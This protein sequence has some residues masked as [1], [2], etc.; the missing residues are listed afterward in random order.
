[1]GKKEKKTIYILK[2]SD[3][4]KKQIEQARKCIMFAVLPIYVVTTMKIATRWL[5]EDSMKFTA[6]HSQRT[7]AFFFH[8]EDAVRCVTENW[9]DIYECGY[10]NIA[11]IEETWQGL[12]PH[13]ESETW[14]EWDKK[15]K[16]YIEIN[17]P[18]VFKN[19]ISFGIG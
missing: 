8:R 1:M 16:G 13:I 19:V 2:D 10:Y 11:I 5:K 12:Y 3:Y 15:K 4:I 18:N 9:G 7:V 6:P 14:F 17:K